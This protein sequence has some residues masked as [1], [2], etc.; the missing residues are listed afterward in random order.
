MIKSKIES[1][2][3]LIPHLNVSTSIIFMLLLG[4]SDQLPQ[5]QLC[6]GKGKGT[7]AMAL[8]ELRR[9]IHHLVKMP[10][11]HWHPAW[12]TES[13]PTTVLLAVAAVAVLQLSYS[14][15]ASGYRVHTLSHPW[16]C[17]GELVPGALCRQTSAAAQVPWI[18]WCSICL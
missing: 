8:H 9:W 6:S 5:W 10:K 13:L 14:K 12:K 17:V 11:P 3:I 15:Y 18:K 7:P 4:V 16:A 1:A 2:S